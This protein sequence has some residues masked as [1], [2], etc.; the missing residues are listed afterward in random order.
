LLGPGAGAARLDRG[1]ARRAD[2]DPLPLRRPRRPAP[3]DRA[4]EADPR[5]G[6]DGDDQRGDRLAALPRRE[7][8]QEPPLLRLLEARRLLAQ[9]GDHGDPRPP[10]GR[11]RHPHD[12]RSVSGVAAPSPVALVHDYLL[13][14][15]GAE[16]TFE[17]IAECWPEAPI[18][19]LL[20]DPEGSEG[21]FE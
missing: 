13:V 8:G 17:A 21:R 4:R 14:R 16:R 7:H 3:A 11:A 9:R 2:R 10:L 6:R 19:T 20:Y 18:Y 12:P 15:R 1:G 5:P